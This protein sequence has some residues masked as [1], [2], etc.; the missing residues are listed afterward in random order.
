MTEHA[1]VT[2]RKPGA[3]SVQAIPG[4]ARGPPL[5]PITVSIK[6]ACELSGLS[7]STIWKLVADGT[8]ESISVGRKRLILFESLETLLRKPA[9]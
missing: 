4:A 3:S 7:R 9:A 8:L 6:T 5:K 2:G 1:G